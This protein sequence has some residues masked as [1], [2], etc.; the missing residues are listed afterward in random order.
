MGQSRR[1]CLSVICGQGSQ[2]GLEKHS[3]EH[4]GVMDLYRR[5][6]ISGHGTISQ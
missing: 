3:D 4:T 2:T 6:Y 1:T 5:I